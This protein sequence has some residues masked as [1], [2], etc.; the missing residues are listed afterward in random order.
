MSESWVI[1]SQVYRTELLEIT[2]LSRIYILKK[3]KYFEK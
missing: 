3:L 2:P 1:G